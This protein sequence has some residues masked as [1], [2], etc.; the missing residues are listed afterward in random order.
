ML[1]PFLYTWLF[2]K[3]KHNYYK[4]AVFSCSTG[5]QFVPDR[6]F[7]PVPLQLTMKWKF[8]FTQRSPGAP[9]QTAVY[10]MRVERFNYCCF[11]QAILLQQSDKG[12]RAERRAGERKKKRRKMQK[13]PSPSPEASA[14]YNRHFGCNYSK[15][16]PLLFSQTHLKR[17]NKKRS[18]L[19]M[20]TGKRG[21]LQVFLSHHKLQSFSIIF[22]LICFIF[23]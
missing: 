21:C 16:I 14:E 1:L 11:K 6:I 4:E 12:S 17:G 20:L 9:P 3:Q 23:P 7:A 15:F 22:L 8:S 18:A 13:M 2:W 10:L 19:S 5:Q